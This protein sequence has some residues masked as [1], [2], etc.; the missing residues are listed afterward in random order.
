M[1]IVPLYG[2]ESF[3]RLKT[4]MLH[5]PTNSICKMNDITKGYYLFD[6]I[7]DTD[8]FLAEHDMYRKLLISQGVEVLELSDF[9]HENKTLL[10]TLASLAY[11][12][13]SSVISQ[14]GAILSQMGG[15]RS[16]EEIVV[17]ES[18][19]NLGIPIAYQFSPEDHFEGC[20]I[21][22]QEILFIACT[23]RH[24]KAA[25]ERFLPTALTLFKEVIYVD[26][27]KERRFMHAD[28]V[29]GQI[30]EDL[31]LAFLPAFLE[32]YSITDKGAECIDFEQ[33]MSKR[34]IEIIRISEQEQKNW[35]CSFV[36]LEP[37]KIIHYDIGLSAKTNKVLSA[38]GVS[39]I[40]FHPYALLAGGGSLRCLTLQIFRE[41]V[42]N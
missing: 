2:T 12:H 40:P 33:H 29:Y 32:T 26:C 7:P 19:L 5:R 35:G 16:G 36:V 4:V 34:G 31:A 41:R 39:I 1:A 3:G 6:A 28:M 10:L 42:S 9:I 14:H 25:I 24:R 21:L 38:R 37:K 27:P 17:K 22:P 13:D 20:L 30:S 23:E 11:L 8:Q 18:L 15:G